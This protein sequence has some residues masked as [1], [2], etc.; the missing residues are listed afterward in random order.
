[1]TESSPTVVDGDYLNA[2]SVQ[3]PLPTYSQSNTIMAIGYMISVANGDGS[4]NY[5]DEVTFIIFDGLCYECNVTLVSC[6]ETVRNDT[7]L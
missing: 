1:M 6:A 7:F 4:G 5:T 3:C 2:F